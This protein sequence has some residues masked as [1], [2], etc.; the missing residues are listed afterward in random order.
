MFL[1]SSWVRKR[2]L[3][4]FFSQDFLNELTS[5]FSGVSFFKGRASAHLTLLCRNGHEPYATDFIFA[6]TINSTHLRS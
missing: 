5:V 1:D 6:Q 4:L 2:F 3:Q